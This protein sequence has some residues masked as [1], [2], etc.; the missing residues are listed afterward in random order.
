[1]VIRGGQVVF[2][3]IAVRPSQRPKGSL[4]ALLPCVHRPLLLRRV[5]DSSLFP[6]MCLWVPVLVACVVDFSR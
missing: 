6:A 4:G 5:P 2:T 3:N 1:M